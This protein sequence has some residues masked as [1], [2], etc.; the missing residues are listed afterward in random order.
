LNERVGL[1]GRGRTDFV[2]AVAF[3]AKLESEAGSS[4]ST[5]P[6]LAAPS[7]A[8][9]SSTTQSWTKP[10]STLDNTKFHSTKFHS[11]KFDNA[12]IILIFLFES[13]CDSYH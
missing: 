8:T 4:S 2:K 9:P 13:S 6:S 7:L 11:P 12:N 5:A 10:S 1:E 3:D